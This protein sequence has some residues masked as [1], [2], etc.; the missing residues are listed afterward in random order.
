MGNC[1]FWERAPRASHPC[2]R[3]KLS[4]IYRDKETGDVHRSIQLRFGV[5]DHTQSQTHPVH[6]A[7][8]WRGGEATSISF[9]PF[10]YPRYNFPIIDPSPPP[11]SP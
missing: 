2:W 4:P 1:L 9:F 6:L 3:G 11:Q 8:H 5:T 7:S 10:F